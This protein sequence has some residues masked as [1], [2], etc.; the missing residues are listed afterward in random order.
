MGVFQVKNVAKYAISWLYLLKKGNFYSKIMQEILRISKIP[1][2]GIQI[3]AI[4]KN[5][6]NMIFLLVFYR[7][8]VI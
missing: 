4:Q 8:I 5:R 3:G 2:K 6:Q 7:G 1:F